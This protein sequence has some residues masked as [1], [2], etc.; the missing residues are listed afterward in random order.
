MTTILSPLASVC[1]DT[2]KGKTSPEDAAVVAAPA[3]PVQASRPQSSDRANFRTCT[4]FESPFGRSGTL[5]EAR[6]L[7]QENGD[8]PRGDSHITLGVMRRRSP[9][10]AALLTFLLAGLA[11]TATAQSPQ[12]ARRTPLVTMVEK[13]S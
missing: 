6:A 13:V 1:L 12:S 4:M 3:A 9:F 8:S 10:S 5:L 7:R 11:A 2:L